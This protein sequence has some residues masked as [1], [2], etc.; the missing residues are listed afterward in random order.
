[1]ETNRNTEYPHH[2]NNCKVFNYPVEECSC[3]E[4]NK[5]DWEVEFDEQ[6]LGETNYLIFKD[7]IK[8]LLSRQE[9]Y[10]NSLKGEICDLNDEIERLD[11]NAVDR[12]NE[13]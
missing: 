2:K 13:L 7:F 12:L 5:E 1:M 11:A 8:S 10:I 6:F 9:A 4:T 3:G